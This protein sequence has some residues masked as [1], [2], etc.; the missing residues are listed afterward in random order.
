[1]SEGRKVFLVRAYHRLKHDSPS[2][3]AFLKE[4]ISTLK[5]EIALN[6]KMS[7]LDIGCGRGY[8]LKYLHE[9]G[10]KNIMGVDPC[11]ELRDARLYDNIIYGSY[12]DNH[13][14]AGAYDVVFTCHT[15]HHLTDSR[16]LYAI[17]EMLRISKRYAVIVEI[18]NTNFPMFIRSLICIG[19]E[20]NAFKYNLN[21]VRHMLSKVDCRVA[22]SAH[23]NTGY[24]SGNSLCYRLFAKIGTPPYNISI[25]EKKQ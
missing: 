13:F 21:R 12:E 24:L 20:K 23:I 6:G 11:K 17:R 1:M 7:L 8:L 14:K 2:I 15:L 18:N 10:Y 4:V 22:Y 19:A 3:Q 5:S 16:P 25:L 9:Q